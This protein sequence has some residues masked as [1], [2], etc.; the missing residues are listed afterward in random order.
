MR[1]YLHGIRSWFPGLERQ[2]RL[3]LGEPDDLALWPRD[4][5]RTDL[6]RNQS[7]LSHAVHADNCNLKKNGICTKTP[8]AYTW[9]DYRYYSYMN[10]SQ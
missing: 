3:V 5:Q 8:P 1:F 9:R 7:H 4:Q 6:P 2:P 10:K